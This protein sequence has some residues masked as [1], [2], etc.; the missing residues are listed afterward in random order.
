MASF[1]G[2]GG[3]GDYIVDGL[4]TDDLGELLLGA[5]SVALLALPS[6]P[7][8]DALERRIAPEGRVA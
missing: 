6:T 8:S 1:I 3:L 5:I 7:R 2:G 4:A